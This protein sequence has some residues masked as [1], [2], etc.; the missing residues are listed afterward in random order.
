MLFL[1]Y[2]DLCFDLSLSL[3]AST[4]STQ[5]DTHCAI[6]SWSSATLQGIPCLGLG[7]EH[8]RFKSILEQVLQKAKLNGGG[9]I[10]GLLLLFDDEAQN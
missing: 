6:E 3:C 2:R 10:L 5:S 4:T 7:A 9:C 1:F 8:R